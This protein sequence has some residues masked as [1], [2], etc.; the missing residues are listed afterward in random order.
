MSAAQIRAATKEDTDSIRVLLEH[1]G[2]PTSDLMSS[3]PQFIVACEGGKILGTGALERFG[4]SALLRS[5][6]VAPER[7]GEGLGRAIVEDLER[8]ARAARITRLILLTHTAQPFF[9]HQG[10]RVIERHESPQDVQGSEEFRS[11]CPASATCM[12]KALAEPSQE[13]L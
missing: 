9:E 13:S 10:Y 7:R 2:L 4:S 6:A 12:A 1:N 5:V 8:I 3:K 11:L